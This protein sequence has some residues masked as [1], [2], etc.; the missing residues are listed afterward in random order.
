MPIYKVSTPDGGIIKF[1]GPEGAS[2]E[3]ILGFAQQ[4][5]LENKRAQQEHLSKTGI[6]N[7]L[8]SG[9][10]S[11]LGASELALGEYTGSDTL[12]QWAAENQKKAAGFEPTTQTDV[13]EAFKKGITSGIAAKFRQAV[14]ED[15][16]SIVGR[17]AGPTAAGMAAGVVLPETGIA[18]LGALGTRAILSGVAT[19][20][21]DLPAE[22]GE[23]IMRQHEQGKDTNLL[24]A[25]AA[26]IGQAAMAGLGLPFTTR[27]TAPV[28]K[29]AEKLAAKVVGGEITKD[30]AIAQTAG[31]AKRLALGSAE[32][33]VAGTG[34]M[35][36]T[37]AL[38][39][40][41]A[42][43]DVLSPEAL[44]EY[45]HE[46]KAAIGL[47]PVFGALHAG[48]LGKMA[49][50]EIGRGEDKRLKREAELQVINDQVKQ[51]A[52]RQQNA[53]EEAQ[54]T[55]AETQ[56]KH[57]AELKGIND[58]ISKQMGF[59][60]SERLS[61]EELKQYKQDYSALLDQRDSLQAKHEAE[62]KA[63]KA[64]L[65]KA[66][67]EMA[68]S[69]KLD[70]AAMAERGTSP[71]SVPSPMANIM[72]QGEAASQAEIAKARKVQ[73]RPEAKP[74][75][76]PTVL[77]E[78]TLGS[79]MPTKGAKA[80]KTLLGK[81]LADPANVKL[82]DDTLTK[83]RGIL[84]SEELEV[85]K[86]S[87]PKE[88]QEALN[89]FATERERAK[90]ARGERAA[91]K[92]AIE[93]PTGI[94]ISGG[95]PAR[96]DAGAA[97]VK[98]SEP[99]GLGTSGLP[100]GEP[101]D[102]AGRV[103]PPVE[104][105]PTPEELKPQVET[106]VVEAPKV[107]A[108]VV[109][110]PVVEAPKQDKKAQQAADRAAAKAK[111]DAER[112]EKEAG[113]KAKATFLADVKKAKED[114]QKIIN[115]R[116]AT[117]NDKREALEQLDSLED[118]KGKTPEERKAELNYAQKFIEGA[119]TR[120]PLPSYTGSRQVNKKLAAGV[121]DAQEALKY[122][123]KSGTVFERLVAN[124]IIH[125]LKDVKVEI[126]RN[127]EDEARMPAKARE[128]FKNGKG[129]YHD[130]VI[131]LR[132]AEFGPDNQGVNNR[133]MLHEALHG[134]TVD[135]I[136]TIRAMLAEGKD[137]PPRLH[138]AFR[139]MEDIME[140]V[141]NDYMAKLDAGV[142]IDPDLRRIMNAI[143]FTEKSGRK[144]MD[145][146]EFLTYGF[147]EPAM[148]KYLSTIEGRVSANRMGHLFSK[149]VDAVRNLFGLDASHQSAF[150]D[151]INAGDKLMHAPLKKEGRVVSEPK[152]QLSNTAKYD[153]RFQKSGVKIGTLPTARE[154][155]TEQYN[156]TKKYGGPL[157]RAFDYFQ[158]MAFSADAGLQNRI[159]REMV[160]NKESQ[161]YIAEA[162]YK[163]A[164][165]QVL[166]DDALAN[167]FVQEGSLKYD[168]T[169]HKWEAAKPK[170]GATWEKIVSQT[171][172]IAAKYD[173]PFD[174]MSSYVQAYL[175]SNRRDGLIK[176]NEEL[177]RAAQVLEAKGKKAKAQELRDEMINVRQTP[178]QIA[179]GLQFIK[180]F[181]EI[182]DVVDTWN[183]VRK[184]A[185]DLSVECGL[186]S[187]EE[188]DRLME[189]MDYVPFHRV[190]QIENRAGYKEYS[191][192]LLDASRDKSLRDSEQ[193]INDLFDNMER[194]TSYLVRK[195]VRNKAANNIVEVVK[196]VLPDEIKEVGKVRTGM[197]ANT[198]GIWQDG[199]RKLYEFADPLMVHAFR[200]MESVAIPALRAFAPFTDFLRKS[201][202]LNPVFS[203][204]QI[205]QD[206]YGAMFT[207]GVKRPLLIPVEVMKQ[208]LS[209]ITGNE[210]Q[211]FKELKARGIAG[212][213]DYSSAVA[214]YDAEVSAGL[215][216]PD[217]KDRFLRPLEKLAML[218][219]NVV[220]QAVYERTMAETGDKALALER[221][222]ELI[223]FRRTGASKS[224][225]ALRQLVPFFGAY[226][227]AQ[228]VAMKTLTGRSI[229]PVERK[230]ALAT[231]ASTTA[232]VMAMSY[233]YSA[234]TNDDEDYQKIDQITKDKHLIVPG[235]GGFMI[236]LRTDAFL[237]PKIAGEYAYRAMID[238]A[239]V[240]STK[241][242]RSMA[243]LAAES[244]LSPTA[245]PQA[246]KPIVEIGMNHNFYT[247]RPIVGLGM[248]NLEK[249]RQ[250]GSS[251]SEF[252]KWLG[253]SNAISP[254]MADHFIKGYTGT[255]GG[256]ALMATDIAIGSMSDVPKPDRSA[257]DV[258]A[259]VP[260]MGTFVSKE[261]GSDTKSDYY[262]LRDMVTKATDTLNNL[263]K[264]GNMAEARE[265]MQANKDLLRV[266]TQVNQINQALSKLRQRESIIR[267]F[268]ESRM[269]GEQ[270]GIEIEKIRQQEKRMLS[271]IHRLRAVAGL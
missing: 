19:S 118:T 222:L 141:E 17:Y 131:Y 270:K 16:A 268:P 257:M 95:E 1:E 139:A 261:F 175:I 214:R 176:K 216:S 226:L 224:V 80:F 122:V 155:L 201:I 100:A 41:A 195:S 209:A 211:A 194:L 248:E 142:N 172:D 200:G 179:E 113:D 14:G 128:F 5:Y 188:A 147:T 163:S 205:A 116:K 269:S 13:D 135:K 20:A 191:R 68:P 18:A 207:S 241:F 252:A 267:D 44:E 138:A 61:K 30:V 93:E 168:P 33:A 40:G 144:T 225:G 259:S 8:K 223:N 149:F 57:E 229:G 247:G 126:I 255:V 103:T 60:E 159:M 166:H 75:A 219:D 63:A 192:G 55:L 26:G 92:P 25:T 239:S 67:A 15:V 180:D 98:E 196:D 42:G 183:G 12:K 3:D 136:D 236:P 244:L 114:L 9:F 11:G 101:V 245:V 262:E 234:L 173:I 220:R 231:L 238:D 89:A 178:E 266:K 228:N 66:V 125:F 109:E 124:R 249:F 215:K 64:A 184:N 129:L 99:A 158:T 46:A 35:I 258:M 70:L 108:P 146:H 132:G 23:N 59:T 242:K 6:M 117:S 217:W 96:E 107:E 50:E 182:K 210:T 85:F 38:R 212:I 250:F 91:N 62:Q 213:R 79:F 133:T 2:E 171:K 202:T 148:Q 112:V 77:T 83:Y 197:E 221:A 84:K 49:R 88:T 240:D 130:G 58:Q 123:A 218:S 174:K 181:P 104:N 10:R 119:Q 256:L 86:A 72:A 185:L 150:L 21:A 106:P 37:E 164:T 254:M 54:K 43:Q 102:G 265:Y 7:A 4:Q 110:A 271:N 74:V 47:A 263:K 56:E 232:K 190:E 246:I 177:E 27:I 227:Q 53:I 51:E 87:L 71:E 127:A 120:E 48:R 165:G 199:N 137:V 145:M 198:I 94:S 208:F 39:R 134:A 162:M 156:E 204:A 160:A 111:R 186:Y 253:S 187:R 251:T 45:G 157:T 73:A 143:F 230:A 152:A 115:D 169:M 90:P 82:F 76:A 243:N 32:A 97:G 81:D 34:M 206:S 151:L 31:L 189:R 28:M 22:V 235:S 69:G 167:I 36:G 105:I 140:R 161:P 29:E 153:E 65:D 170:N 24:S 203:M 237:L 260:G 193:E 121:K 233:I 78:D 52:V 264:T 154:K